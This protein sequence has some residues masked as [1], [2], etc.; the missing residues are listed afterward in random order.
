MYCCFGDV[1]KI[2]A[3]R[4]TYFNWKKT[5]KNEIAVPVYHRLAELAQLINFIK[6][7]VP[8]GVG[9]GIMLW[10]MTVNYI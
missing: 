9:I 10:L 3:V 6:F 1:E 5:H 4:F 7:S 2:N 8:V